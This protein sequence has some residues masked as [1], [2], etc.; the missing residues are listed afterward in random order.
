MRRLAIPGLVALAAVALLALLVFG[1]VRNTANTSL[2]AQ[3]ARGIDPVAP[4]STLMLPVLGAHR[5]EDLADLRGKVVVVN[6]FASWCDPCAA[7]APVL[8]QEQKEIAGRN[9]TVIGVTY[10]DAAPA[11]QHFVTAHGI[12]YPVL[13]DVD[14]N[15]THAY[16]GTGVPETYVID[17]QGR[18]TAIRRSVIDSS[19]LNSTL[20]PLLAQRA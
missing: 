18:V 11:S 8:E 2:D 4:E 10:L 6:V 16:G 19:W 1:I 15:F 3:L 5:S 20:A 9:A 12:T 17:R 13:R 7:E 14:G